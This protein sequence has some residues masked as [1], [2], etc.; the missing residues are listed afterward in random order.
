MTTVATLPMKP[1][2]LEVLKAA[3][4]FS[5]RNTSIWFRPKAL[6]RCS[7]LSR[8]DSYLQSL[9]KRG[10]IERRDMGS[11]PG[12]LGRWEYR[13]TSA[14]LQFL[15]DGAGQTSTRAHL[16]TCPVV[17]W[18]VVGKHH[19]QPRPACNCGAENNCKQPEKES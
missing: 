12:G 19:C 2:A 3:G 4:A 1:G 13:I 6:G 11:R 8:F 5:F 7:F 14:G 15:Q 18:E 17:M 9:I 16:H 10:L